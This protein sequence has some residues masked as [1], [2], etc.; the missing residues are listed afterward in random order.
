MFKIV[1]LFGFQFGHFQPIILN[2]EGGG[3]Q[4]IIP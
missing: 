4:N 3:G 2:V 1:C